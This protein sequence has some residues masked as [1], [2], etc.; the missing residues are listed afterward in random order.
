MYADAPERDHPDSVEPSLAL[1]H[2]PRYPLVVAPVDLQPASTRQYRA[3]TEQH[4]GERRLCSEEKL[5]GEL[6]RLSINH[7]RPSP[8]L[9]RERRPL[10]GGR[11]I[12]HVCSTS[13]SAACSLQFARRATAA[14]VSEI[15]SGILAS[16][17]NVAP[18]WRALLQ[19]LL[20]GT[21][22]GMLSPVI[23]SRLHSSAWSTAPR[24]TWVQSSLNSETRKHS[25]SHYTQHLQDVAGWTANQTH[26]P[27]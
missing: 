21:Q 6:N 24:Y 4:E 11:C 17:R 20:G 16:M 3:C 2:L 15:S 9:C 12:C 10:L 18:S 7:I 26:R 13:H 23:C 27:L 22:G 25:R 1:S 14:A 8:S 5:S 19:T